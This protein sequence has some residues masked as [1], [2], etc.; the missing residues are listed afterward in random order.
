MWKNPHF[1]AA[2]KGV[3]FG[4]LFFFFFFLKKKKKIF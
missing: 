1:H 3:R 4:N 2:D